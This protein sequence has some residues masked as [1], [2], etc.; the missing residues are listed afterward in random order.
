MADAAD[1]RRALAAFLGDGQYR[2]FVKQGVHRGRLRHWQ[3]EAWGRFTAAYPK[4]VVGPDELAAAIRVCHLHGDELRPD[5]AA[6]FHGCRDLSP[7]YVEARARL[8]PNAAQDEVSTEGRPFD[9]DRLGVWFCPSC[10]KAWA[11][12]AGPRQTAKHLIRPTTLDELA[13]FWGADVLAGPT[14]ARWATFRA[15]VEACLAA[16]GELWEWES[17]GFMELC[18]DAGVAVVRDGEWVGDWHLAKS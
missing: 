18:G 11:A 8:F 10:R 9:G 6:V 12:W 13:E 2:K 1:L 4:F 17:D 3:E 5:A 15:E 14:A 7:R 16:G